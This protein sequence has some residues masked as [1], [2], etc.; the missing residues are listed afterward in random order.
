MQSC[1]QSF[2][3]AENGLRGKWTSRKMDFAENGS[4]SRFAQ[5]MRKFLVGPDYVRDCTFRRSL[6]TAGLAF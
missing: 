3:F 1:I 4:Y 5:H 2:D 6:R